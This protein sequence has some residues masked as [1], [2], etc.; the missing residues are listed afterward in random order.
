MIFEIKKQKGRMHPR[1][2]LKASTASVLTAFFLT[3]CSDFFEPVDSTPAP[4]EYTYNYWLLQRTYLFEDE[5][6]LLDEQGD[7][8]SEL[9]NKLSDPFTRYVPPAKSEATKNQINT[10]IVPGDVGMEYSAFL[11][12]EHPLVIYRVYTESPAGRAG[13]PRYGNILNVN[14]VEIVGERAK[15]IYDSVLTF[16][17]N[18][19]IKV[20]HQGDTVTYNITKEDVYAPTVFIDTLNGTEVITITSFKLNTV[21]KENGTLGELTTYLNATRN[22]TAPRLIDLRNNPGGHVKHCTAMADL[23][24]KDGILSTRSW[25]GFA[26]DGTPTYNTADEMAKQGDAG[27]GKKFM[28]LVNRN[29]ASCA[30]IFAAALQEG[31]KIPVAGDT[32][33]GKG[34]GQSTWNT[35]NG[36]LAIITNL[37]FLTPNGNS[38]NKKGIA[39]KYYCKSPSIICGLEA[40]QK[41]YGKKVTKT[42]IPSYLIRPLQRTQSN[43]E[44]GAFIDGEKENL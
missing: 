37:E 17:R 43:L 16:N 44:G 40:I 12:S 15:A 26:G 21:D 3:A 13:I 34:I 29:S 38:Y 4:T 22:T 33:Y 41:H 5:L 28:L 27:E 31:A 30:E 39:P 7:S 42:H 11:Q 32:T 18:L 35:L 24:I 6:P 8:V 36:G 9:Y 10:S 14:G 19:A 2:W 1:S 25:R 23:F 20:A